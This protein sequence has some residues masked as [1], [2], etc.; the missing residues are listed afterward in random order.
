MNPSANV[1][2]HSKPVRGGHYHLFKIQR[3]LQFLQFETN[4]LSLMGLI[5]PTTK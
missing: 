1:S 4:L 5:G 2:P 3:V